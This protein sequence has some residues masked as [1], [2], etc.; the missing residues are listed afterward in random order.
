[1]IGKTV[2][3]EMDFSKIKPKKM[4]Q[5]FIAKLRSKAKAAAAGAT[6]TPAPPPARRP[7]AAPGPLAPLP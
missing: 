4:A 1:M 2:A 7:G 5:D 6:V 3:G